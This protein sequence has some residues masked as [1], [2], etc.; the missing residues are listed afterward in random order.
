MKRTKRAYYIGVGE[1]CLA[2]I[3]IRYR[4][5]ARGLKLGLF[6]YHAGTGSAY[7]GF[8]IGAV[9]GNSDLMRSAVGGMDGYDICC[10]RTFTKSLNLWFFII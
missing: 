1:V 8:I 10:R 5:C 6:G 7:H 3:H 2:S 4:K 9:N